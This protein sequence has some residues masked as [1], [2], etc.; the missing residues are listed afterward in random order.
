MMISKINIYKASSLSSLSVMGEDAAA[1]LNSQ[2]SADL[3]QPHPGLCAYGL[4]LDAKGKVQADSWVLCRDAET[5]E[6]LSLG[7]EAAILKEKLE[8]HIIADD[9]VIELMNGLSL[10][11]LQGEGAEKFVDE[12]LGEVPEKEGF[13]E[14]E[15]TLCFQG[16]SSRGANYNFFYRDNLAAN[17]AF[18][19]LEAAGAEAIDWGQIELSRIA[20]GIPAIPQE[21]GVSDLPGEAGL[22]GV[23]VCT[24]KGCFLGQESILRM[25]NLGRARRGLYAVSGEGSTPSIPSPLVVAGDKR[26]P[27]ELRSA[28]VTASGWVG[29][30]M[31]KLD[32]LEA[33]IECEGQRIKVGHA[34][35]SS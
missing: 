19:Q 30:A 17:A 1:F 3:R 25:H 10:L 31:L 15:E 16:R 8:K 9:V 26:Q 33:D 5:Y 12:L 35:G 28:Y 21:L 34:M 22:V 6:I 14:T 23:E 29:V 11:M 7:T 4:W 2:F 32:R 13:I 27:G 20:A 24:T 18:G